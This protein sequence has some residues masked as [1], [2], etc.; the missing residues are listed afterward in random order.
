LARHVVPATLVCLILSDVVGGPLDSIAS[1]PTVPDPTT[2]TDAYAVLERYR[3]LEA[4]P[5][6]IIAHLQKGM[7]GEVADTPKEGDPCFDRVQNVII[8]DNRLAALAAES[9][10]R[11]L[12]LRSEILTTYAEGEARDVGKVCAA[13]AKE[14]ADSGRPLTPPACLILGGE[15]TV[16]LRG[17]GR[18]GRNQELALAAALALAGWERTMIASLATDGTD[19]PTDAAGALVDGDTI[20]RAQALGLDARSYL[21]DNDSYTF[22]AALGDL[23]FTGPTN[24]N[25]NDLIFVFAL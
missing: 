6:S 20:T 10:A 24:T 9:R 2:F 25:V 17:K 22:F 14:M 19:G 16:T 15:T 12:G 1:G 23:V 11:D 13:L 3:A 18:G 4:V 7:A 5:G 21:A 8:G